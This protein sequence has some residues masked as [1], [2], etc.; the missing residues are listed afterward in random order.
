MRERERFWAEYYRKLFRV[1]DPWLDYSNGRVQIQTFAAALEAAGP[2]EGRRCLDVGCGRGQFARALLGLNASA[3]TGI[4]IVPEVLEHAATA[5]AIRWLCGSLQDSTFAAYLERYDLVFLLE[6]LQYVPLGPTLH[7]VW[8]HVTPGGR[9]VVVV[10]NGDC[11]IAARTRSR[12]GACYDPPTG[13][14]VAAAVDALP[15]AEHWA[16]RGLFF[17]ADQTVA[18]YELSPWGIKTQWTVTPNRLQFVVLKRW[19]ASGERTI[20]MG[21][22][23]AA[24]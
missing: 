15:D 17:G 24:G 21:L 14:Q 23:D 19:T 4:D 13:A 12:F 11:P 1:G 2:V 16:L 6:V 8:R 5:P 20:P 3:V 18:P 7:A 9:V 10:P 22:A